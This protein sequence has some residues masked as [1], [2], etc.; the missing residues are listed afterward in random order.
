MQE[1]MFRS[2]ARLVCSCL[3]GM[4]FYLSCVPNS[5]ANVD[6]SVDVCQQPLAYSHLSIAYYIDE[7]SSIE[8]DLGEVKQENR[9]FDLLFKL[10]NKWSLGAGHRYTILNVDPLKL[11]TN[12][13]LHTF[14]GPLHIQSQSGRRGF[15]FSIAPAL[16]ASSNYVKDP[17]EY[18][19]D[20]LQLL[21]ALV[22]SKQLSDRTNVRYGVCGDHRF[23]SYKI[24]PLV[25][26]DWQPHADWTIEL[27]FPTSRLSYQVSKSLSSSLRFTPDGNEWH[28]KDKSLEKQ[29]QLVYEA[30][31]LEWAFNW[32]V[33]KRFSITASVGR[34]F[35]N[36]YVM[37]LLDESHVQLSSDSVTR[38][39]AAIA[40]R[41]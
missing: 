25:S 18:N 17:G 14:Y 36:R 9:V 2:V 34:K 1:A 37:T 26:V 32:Q 23:G 24:Y 15:R 20:A 21:A 38:I 28:V 11:Q 16:S 31:L 33:H 8:R 40:W 7:K 13:H 41:F 39:G 29:S 4:C 19:A 30:Y 6:S 12:G 10:N 3:A 5:L 27:G 22:W 35:H